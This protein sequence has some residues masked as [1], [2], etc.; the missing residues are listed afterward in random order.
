MIN[1]SLLTLFQTGI[2]LYRTENSSSIVSKFESGWIIASV[3][4]WL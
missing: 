2:L 4:R 1:V 3:S